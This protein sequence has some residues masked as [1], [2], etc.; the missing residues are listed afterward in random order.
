MSE[1]HT[2]V[3][4]RLPLPLDVVGTLMSLVGR[5]YDGATVTQYGG[6]MVFRIPDRAR[7]RRLTD[8]DCAPVPHDTDAVVE[9]VGPDELALSDENLL[10]LFR[11][12]WPLLHA[13]LEANP[14][15][16]NY[17]EHGITV[18]TDVPGPKAADPA[19]V[20]IVARSKGQTPHQLRVA[21][22]ARA[23]AAE[24]AFDRLLERVREATGCTGGLEELDVALGMLDR[25]T[26]GL[27]PFGDGAA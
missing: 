6:D 18:E 19:Y 26:E 17:L 14:A 25:A 7:P 10:A 20:L 3:R 4:V 2:D 13:D 9:R 5:A 24:A 8:D 23:D 27:A 12:F 21:A 22:E 16:V 15:A 1:D 11:R